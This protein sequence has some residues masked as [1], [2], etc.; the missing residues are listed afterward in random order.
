MEFYNSF[1]E[2][3]EKNGLTREKAIEL[4]EIELERSVDHGKCRDNS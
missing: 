3:C 1:K 4:L 2:F